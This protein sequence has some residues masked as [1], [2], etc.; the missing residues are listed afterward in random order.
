M[1]R[2]IASRM[3]FA[4]ASAK[5]AALK[6]VGSPTCSDVGLLLR[7]PERLGI[8]TAERD[9]VGI[10][11]PPDL[12]RR[13]ARLEPGGVEPR[14]APQVDERRHVHDREAR[15]ASAG[16]APEQR[17]QV[18]RRILRLLHGEPD[19]VVGRGIGA[20]RRH[21]IDAPRQVRGPDRTMRALAPQ[22]QAD[23]DAL[24][25]DQRRGRLAAD[26]RHVVTRHRQL[27]AE[28]GSVGCAE[29]Q[30]LV[31][32]DGLHSWAPRRMANGGGTMLT[33]TRPSAGRSARVAS[34]LTGRA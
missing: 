34:V 27:G 2:S 13:V 29:D 22:L 16:D 28:E 4:A 23:L 31:G 10:E 9:E 1:S 19:H 15:D 12:R 6:L 5:R 7:R 25:V 30:N 18:V 26:Q 11:L 20:R 8:G 33:G 32:H 3:P 24:G 17:P 21:R 14:D